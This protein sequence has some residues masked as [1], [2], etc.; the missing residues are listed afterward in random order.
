MTG[1]IRKRG[2]KT[3]ELKY[4]VG[5]DARGKRKTRYVSFKGTKKEASIE[6]ARLVAEAA[7][8]ES[9]DP[10][11]L[12]VGDW[13]AQWTDAEAP[14][15]RKKKVS[16][17]TLEGYS[18]LLRVHVKPTLGNV[19]L[20][21]LQAIQIDKLY[22]ELEGNLSPMSLHHLHT[23]FNSCLSTAER[24]GLI[25]INPMRRVEQ[26]PSAEESD[27]GEALEEADLKTLVAGFEP[28]EDMFLPVAV[29]AATGG[30]RNELLAF[31]WIDFDPGQ[32]TLRVEQAIEVTRKFGIR[33]KA[34][35]TW[36]GKRTILIDDQTSELLLSERDRHK[37]LLA[38][39][40]DGI[41]EVDLSLIVLPDD[42]LI[43]F[44]PPARGRNFIDL[45]MPRDP[46]NFSAAFRK[47]ADELGF[48]GFHF[49]H[50]RGTHATLL[51]DKGEPVHVVAE[52]IGDDPAVLLK[53][54]AK[55]KR[56]QVANKTVAAT[57]N[58]IAT[59]IHR[60]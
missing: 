32:K 49:H 53:N 2:E 10:N 26:V 58:A 16:Q 18:D 6:L 27:H 5:T 46:G 12:T 30:R 17:R 15:R 36:R 47:R 45:S 59:A 48:D 14:G 38:G 28:I 21:K 8:G 34:P 22:V 4:D 19:K 43:F 29:D 23:C 54:Y 11:K 51:L 39:I 20:Q 37:R 42:A 56:K 25:A 60:R 9:I 3:W 1:H 52:R 40:P 50:L 57:I 44:R 35:K 41:P 13:F 33:F 31:R 55:R 7:S 24:K